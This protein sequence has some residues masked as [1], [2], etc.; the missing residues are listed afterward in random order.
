MALRFRN[1]ARPPA[2]T[3][4]RAAGADVVC[5]RP[6]RTADF[7]RVVSGCRRFSFGMSVS[8]GYPEATVNMAAVTREVGVS[9]LINTSQMHSPDEQPEH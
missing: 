2:A 6:T 5:R 9:L 7:Y 4:L 8:A 1:T 3:R